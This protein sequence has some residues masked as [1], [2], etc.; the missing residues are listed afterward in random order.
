MNSRT[1]GVRTAVSR[2]TLLGE[3]GLLTAIAQA[4][5]ERAMAPR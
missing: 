3:G 2:A 4:A 1:A 5:L